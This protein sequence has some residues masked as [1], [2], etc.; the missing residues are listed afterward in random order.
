LIIHPPL[1]MTEEMM[2]FTSV[3]RLA[4]LIAL[5]VLIFAAAAI[6]P[7]AARAYA[8]APDAAASAEAGPSAMDPAKTIIEN[9]AKSR[10][11]TTLLAALKAAGLDAALSGPGPLILFAPTDAA[12]AKLPKD[13]L[14]DL[15]KPENKAKLAAILNYHI[16]PGRMTTHDLNEIGRMG[17]KIPMK[18][19][20]G[21]VFDITK[22]TDDTFSIRDESGGTAM[23]TQGDA[24]QSNGVVF[25]ID[26]ILMP[27]P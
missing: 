21:G 13:K 12:F 8:A 27:K 26:A 18:T 23:I 6:H 14:D 7:G 16:V 11:H 1:K 20:Q 5:A 9:L 19:L 24:A 22:I 4:G 2:R 15:M 10:D 3:R 25:V 17:N